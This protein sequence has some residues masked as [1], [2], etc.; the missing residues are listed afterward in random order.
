MPVFV[1]SLFFYLLVDAL[2]LF[3]FHAAQENHPDSRFPKQKEPPPQDQTAGTKE[4]GAGVLPPGSTFPL[5]SGYR[6][7]KKD[8]SKHTRMEQDSM[9]TVSD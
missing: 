6:M 2:L 5:S 7:T 1:M 8:Y 4:A 9:L 3:I